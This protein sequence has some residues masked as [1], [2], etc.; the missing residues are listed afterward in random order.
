MAVQIDEATV[1]HSHRK[2]FTQ[3]SGEITCASWVDYDC[4]AGG[5]RGEYN[6]IRKTTHGL[7][8]RPV[9]SRLS[10]ACSGL[11]S[12]GGPIAAIRSPAIATLRTASVADAGSITR[13]FANTTSQRTSPSE[14]LVVVGATGRICPVTDPSRSSALVRFKHA[15]AML[16]VILRSLEN[17]P[18]CVRNRCDASARACCSLAA[19]PAGTSE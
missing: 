12:S 13:P 7:T 15:V 1:K 9:Q 3:Q 11:T 5:I 17:G 19:V 16:L 14:E 4:T 10:R 8:T 6:R 2:Q 18:N